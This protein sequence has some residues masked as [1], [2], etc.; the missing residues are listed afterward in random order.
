MLLRIDNLNPNPII[1]TKTLK[2]TGL[3]IQTHGIKIENSIPCTNAR[4][5]ESKLTELFYQDIDAITIYSLSTI[6]VSEK[7]VRLL[8]ALSLKG[9]TLFLVSYEDE[10]L[11]YA[12]FKEENR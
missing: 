8:K 9:V 11:R 10:K 3:I 5:M 6:N 4:Q 1:Q 7:I 2:K 12:D